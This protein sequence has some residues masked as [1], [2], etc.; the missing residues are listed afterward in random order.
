MPAYLRAL[1]DRSCSIESC[2]HKAVVEVFDRWNGSVGKF[3]R[4]HGEK[5]VTRLNRRY[6]EIRQEVRLTNS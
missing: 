6:E 2:S 3:C 5:E 1:V 4:Q